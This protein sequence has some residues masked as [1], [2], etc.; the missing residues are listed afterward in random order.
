MGW[1]GG[2]GVNIQNRQTEGEKAKVGKVAVII[3]DKHVWRSAI[4]ER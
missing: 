3:S 1:V 4:T 2:R